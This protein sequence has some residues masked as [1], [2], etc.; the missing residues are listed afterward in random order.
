MKDKDKKPKPK[1]EEEVNAPV[2]QPQT[3][4]EDPELPPEDI[5]PEGE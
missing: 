3:E 4:G 5:P 2:A 1:D